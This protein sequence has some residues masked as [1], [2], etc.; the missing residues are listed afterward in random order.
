METL[1]NVLDLLAGKSDE[2]RLAGLLLVTKYEP[3]SPFFYLS[4]RS[5]CFVDY[6]DFRLL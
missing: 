1:R 2:S 4:L 3:F 6:A 5:E